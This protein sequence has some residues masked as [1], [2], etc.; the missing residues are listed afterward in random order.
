MTTFDAAVHANRIRG[1]DR[2]RFA[3]QQRSESAAALQVGSRWDLNGHEEFLDEGRRAKLV[4]FKRVNPPMGPMAPPRSSSSMR[5]A[6]AP[7]KDTATGSCMMNPVS[8]LRSPGTTGKMCCSTWSAATAGHRASWSTRHPMGSRRATTPGTTVSGTSIT[9]STV[10]ESI[11][12]P[13]QQ[14]PNGTR[15]T[16]ARSTRGG[17]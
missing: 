9:A 16:E 12:P 13:V 2:G 17:L 3:T 14:D 11:S 15:P 10:A 6:A 8:T 4:H 1:N 5:M 7:K